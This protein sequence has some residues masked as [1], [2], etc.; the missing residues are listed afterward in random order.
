MLILKDKTN[1]LSGHKGVVSIIKTLHDNNFSRIRIG[2]RDLKKTKREKAGA[3][4]LTSI[5]AKN[6]KLIYLVFGDARERVI[7]NDTLPFAPTTRDVRGKS[8][9]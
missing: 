7:E 4:V 6:K 9:F 5:N 1:G 2:V 3:F 8:T